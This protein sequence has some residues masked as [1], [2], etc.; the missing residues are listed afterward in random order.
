MGCSFDTANVWSSTE[1]EPMLC[2]ATSFKACGNFVNA[3]ESLYDAVPVYIRKV[4]IE[5]PGQNFLHLREVEVFDMNGVNVAKFKPARQSTTTTING[6][7]LAIAGRAVDGIFTTASWTTN[8]PSDPRKFRYRFL[9]DDKTNAYSNIW[10]I[11]HKTS[12]TTGPFWE[13]DLGTSTQ[14]RSVRIHNQASNSNQTPRLSNAIVTLKNGNDQDVARYQFGSVDWADFTLTM[15]SF[16]LVNLNPMRVNVDVPVNPTDF[17]D[18]QF[19]AAYN[20][21]IDSSSGIRTIDPDNTYE[22]AVLSN[23][24]EDLFCGAT[25]GP[26]SV[27]AEACDA[28]MEF[29]LGPGVS[30]GLLNST[31]IDVNDCELSVF[32]SSQ[33]TLLLSLLLHTAFNSQSQLILMSPFLNLVGSLGIQTRII[34]TVLNPSIN[35]WMHTSRL[36]IQEVIQFGWKAI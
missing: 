28:S 34:P 6:D 27:L 25:Q 3:F 23:K 19:P 11:F 4:R 14:I 36:R 5:L 24:P 10:I 21:I 26:P 30:I 17:S 8:S 9:C 18:T 33:Y 16:T 31:A 20:W 15:D 2:P 29:L 13:V 7:T 35:G 1:T 32:V 12:H 22:Y